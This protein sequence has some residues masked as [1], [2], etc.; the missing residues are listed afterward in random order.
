[1]SKSWDYAIMAKKASD[2]G[3]PEKWL[4]LIKKGAYDAGAS[5]M[6]NK[7]VLPLLA[8]G[9]GIGA[10]CVAGGQTIHKWVVEKKKERLITEQEAVNAEEYL[11]KELSEAVNKLQSKNGEEEE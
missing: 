8:T 2:A 3:G 4:E 7:L 6:K 9:V 11:K 10:V 1:M 5:D